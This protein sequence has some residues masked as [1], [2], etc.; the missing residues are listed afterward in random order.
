MTT[1]KTF[2]REINLNSH[3]LGGKK[4]VLQGMRD[5]KKKNPC[6]KWEVICKGCVESKI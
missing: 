1:I 6:V 3:L 5:S 4:C 2:L